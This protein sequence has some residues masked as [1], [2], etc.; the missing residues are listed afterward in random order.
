MVGKG[1]RIESYVVGERED[2]WKLYE[3]GAK[4]RMEPYGVRENK[5]AWSLTLSKEEDA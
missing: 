3:V 1:K 5:D 2:A 4:E